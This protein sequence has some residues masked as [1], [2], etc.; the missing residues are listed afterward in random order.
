[1]RLGSPTGQR[2]FAIYAELSNIYVDWLH[3]VDAAL[4]KLQTIRRKNVNLRSI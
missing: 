1:M 3:C 2:L 4:S